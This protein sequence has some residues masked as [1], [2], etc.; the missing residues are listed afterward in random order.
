M[1]F[2]ITKIDKSIKKDNSG[3][4]VFIPGTKKPMVEIKLQQE[5][6]DVSLIKT[7]R[8][9]KR[10]GKMYSDIKGDISVMYLK[11]GDRL[12]NEDNDS[13]VEKEKTH[14]MH[15]LGNWIEI[16]NNVNRLILTGEQSEPLPLDNVPKSTE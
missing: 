12:K 5:S 11:T 6:I 1:K 15:I 16:T 13:D 2:F 10:F 4:I 9:F 8:E 14:E 3:A 7:T